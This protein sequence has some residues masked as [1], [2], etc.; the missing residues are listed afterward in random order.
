MK[1][2]VYCLLIIP[3]ILLV[4][5]SKT[6]ITSAFILKRKYITTTLCEKRSL[7][8]N[9]C[10]G[11]CFLKKEFAKDDKK[12][13]NRIE[14]CKIS[15]EWIDGHTTKFFKS[16]LADNLL[17]TKIDKSSELSGFSGTQFQPPETI[18]LVIC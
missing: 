10:K 16:I 11:K 17:S 15:F 9:H 6:L 1:N 3:A 5:L 8:V 13:Q 7:S 2:R 18:T 14:N 12:E 4:T